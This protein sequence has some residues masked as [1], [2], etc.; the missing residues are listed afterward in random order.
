MPQPFE[1]IEGLVKTIAHAVAKCFRHPEPSAFADEFAAHAK[2]AHEAAQ[3]PAAP[4][5]PAAPA[6]APEA[7]PQAPAS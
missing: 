1:E 2:E 3:V 4:A 6:P 5:A 7:A